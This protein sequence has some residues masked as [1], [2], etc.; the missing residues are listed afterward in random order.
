MKDRGSKIRLFPSRGI[1]DSNEL[2]TIALFLMGACTRR[3]QTVSKASS[4]LVCLSFANYTR[5]RY[6]K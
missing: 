2:Y 5:N 3:M 6:L 4:Y 1:F